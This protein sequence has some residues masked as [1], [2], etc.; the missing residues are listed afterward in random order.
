MARIL[1][2]SG[3][4]CAS[5]Q[6]VVATH[7]PSICVTVMPSSN[8]RSRMPSRDRPA[9]APGSATSGLTSVRTP[10]TPRS[11]SAHGPTAIASVP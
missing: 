7:L 4:A 10:S 5:A 2:I 6:S 3:T 8:C 9:H 11:T 1:P